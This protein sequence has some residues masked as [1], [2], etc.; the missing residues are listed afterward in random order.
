MRTLIS[1]GPISGYN[2][3]HGTLISVSKP[4]GRGPVPGDMR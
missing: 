4:A 2:P 1:A 3:Q